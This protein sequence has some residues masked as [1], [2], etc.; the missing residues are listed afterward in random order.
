ME[1]SLLKNE[2]L[3]EADNELT[4]LSLMKNYLKKLIEQM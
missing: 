2:Y 3:D 1:K 4:N